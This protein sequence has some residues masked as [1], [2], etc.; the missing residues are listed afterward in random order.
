LRDACW[1]P[2]SSPGT[3]PLGVEVL[4]VVEEG[5]ARGG[6]GV[7]CSSAESLCCR[8][9]PKGLPNGFPS[10]PPLLADPTSRSL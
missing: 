6:G 2:G 1:N 3:N 4:V 10:A 7:A 5:G 9:R 8:P